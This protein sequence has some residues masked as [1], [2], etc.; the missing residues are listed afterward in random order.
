MVAGGPRISAAIRERLRA[1]PGAPALVWHG[2]EISYSALDERA[3]RSREQL[4]HLGLTPGEPL[5]VLGDK[6]PDAVALLLACLFTRH[7]VLLLSP[8]LADT[9]VTDLVTRAGCRHVL[10]PSGGHVGG[11]RAVKAVA[12]PVPDDTAFLLTTSGS[13]GIP[14]IVPL[15]ERAVGRFAAWAGPAFGIGPGVTVLSHAPLNFDLCLFDI[16]T[17]LAHG[18]RVVLVDTGRATSGSHLV[19]LVDRHGVDVM[20]AVPMAYRLL[21]DAARADGRVLPSVRQALVTGDVL[22]A[23][24]LAGLPG[25]FPAA[26]LYNVYGCTETNDSFSHEIGPGDT[27]RVPIGRPL[28]GT[29]ALVLDGGGGIVDGA[30]T[31]ELYVSTP[32]Q[33]AGYLDSARS[34]GVFCGHPLGADRR[35]W[36]RTGDLV[37][38]DASGR[39]SLIGRTDFQVKVRGVAVNTAEIEQTLLGHPEVWEAGVA[40]RP[41]P[42]GGRQLVSAVRRAPGSTLNSL[43]LRAYSSRHLPRGAVPALMHITDEPLPKTST[44]KVDRSAVTRMTGPAAGSHAHREG[45]S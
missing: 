32:F 41:D 11:V 40:A 19:D 10:T 43:E 9:L 45:A 25:L 37:R 20:Q 28:P 14:K 34:A 1:Q 42:V 39:L 33:S 26:R 21:M 8:R 35:G 30:G 12:R 38:R 6:S 7:P 44:G 15:G 18:A 22:P 4:A 17:S 13:T 29:R 36:Y 2:E 16:W 23:Q 27:D 5:A 24:T 31:G 3:G